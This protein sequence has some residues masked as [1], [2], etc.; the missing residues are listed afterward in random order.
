MDNIEQYTAFLSNI[1]GD[2]EVVNHELVHTLCTYHAYQHEPWDIA[3]IV[4]D[5]GIVPALRKINLVTQSSI[6]D[7]L[8]TSF[9]KDHIQKMTIE[10]LDHYEEARQLTI[11]YCPYQ[12][13]APWEDKNAI[14]VINIAID[15][16]EGTRQHEIV[17]GE[18]EYYTV[19]EEI[20]LEFK[21]KYF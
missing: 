10:K 6:T 3:A 11:H 20:L 18:I 1:L 14:I 12:T 19:T 8:N 16:M 5:F 13:K 9:I 4:R 7:F 2:G 21:M 15:F 17:F